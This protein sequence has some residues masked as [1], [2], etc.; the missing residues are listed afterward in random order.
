MVHVRSGRS[1]RAVRTPRES[2]G[3]PCSRIERFGPLLRCTGLWCHAASGRGLSLLNTL[4][5]LPKIDRNTAQPLRIPVAEKYKVPC[6][7]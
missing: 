7:A 4:D 6:A 1:R 5:E 2:A 3:L